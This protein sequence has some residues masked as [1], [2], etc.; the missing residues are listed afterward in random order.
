[1]LAGTDKPTHHGAA[2][3][4]IDPAV[5]GPRKEFLERVDK[6]IDEIH[7][8]PTSDGVERIMVPGDREFAQLERS[9]R[10]PMV[11][12]SDVAQNV[13]QAAEIVGLQIADYAELAGSK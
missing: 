10:K 4:A 9:R 12:L 8:T 2:F 7:A 13:R 3:I 5:L 6:L 1:M 11:L